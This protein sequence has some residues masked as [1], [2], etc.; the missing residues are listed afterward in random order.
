[1]EDL[2]PDDLM[3]NVLSR[4]PVKTIIRY[5]CVCKKWRDLVSDSYFVNLHLSRSR[6]ALMIFN[7]YE[8]FRPGNL[9]WVE[10]GHKALVQVK[11]LVLTEY[12]AHVSCYWL[13]QVGSVNGLICSAYHCRGF[14]IYNPVLEECMHVPP[15]PQEYETLSYGLGVSRAGEYKLI[16]IFHRKISLDSDELYT[17]EIEVYTLH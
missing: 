1:M 11:R 9:M 13:S 7:Y 3:Y 12:C 2:L 17:V 4:L 16:H 14:L 5:K 8:P 6:E 15:P 10:I